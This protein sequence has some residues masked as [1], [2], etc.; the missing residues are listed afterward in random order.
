MS[1]SSETCGRIAVLGAGGF[2]GSRLVAMARLSHP[3]RVIPVI[4]SHKA[5]ARL[6]ESVD[7]ARVCDTSSPSALAAVLNGAESVVNLINGDLLKIE[8]DT[9]LIHQACL[10]A[11]VQR[12]VHISSAVVFGRV[13]NPETS[14]DSPPDIRSWML[15]ARGKAKAEVFLRDQLPD[16]RLK[17]VVL[18]PGIIWGPMSHWAKMVGEQLNS[19][20]AILPGNGQ[21]VAN[22]IYIDNLCQ[23]IL[24]VACS[25]SGPTGFYNIGDEKLITWLEYYRAIALRLGF[26][27]TDVRT[28]PSTRLRLAPR[29]LIEIA[30][31]QPLLYRLMKWTLK[32][33]GGG[34]K[35][36]LKTILQG[37]PAP[38][39]VSRSRAAVAPNLSLEHRAL[40]STANRLSPEKLF[41]DYGPLDFVSSETGFDRTAAW[42]RFSGYQAPTEKEGRK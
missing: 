30:A 33:I 15:Y 13:S 22:L 36:L 16:P 1:S 21:G 3:G 12:L 20:R 39:T 24:E 35:A 6:R 2:V 23:A 37:A 25:K 4:R 11:G 29:H 18:R 42:L 40:F 26:S 5:L 27:Q 10:A 41:R 38:P 34:P 31:Q 32:R 14:D 8:A 9:R 7:D 28:W 17:P 19:D